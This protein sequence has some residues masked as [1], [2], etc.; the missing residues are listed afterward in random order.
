MKHLYAVSLGVL[1][2]GAVATQAE[3]AVTAVI[4]CNPCSSLYDLQVAAINWATAQGMPKA[5]GDIVL[6]TSLNVPI[7]AYYKMDMA[8]RPRGGAYYVAYQITA[9][10][11][12]AIALDNQIYA[13]AAKVAPIK[14]P[15]TLTY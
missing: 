6:V 10:I 1:A 8:Y 11:A 15:S 5:V 12:G 3:A 9:D 14:T 13:R 2:C 7:S 4:S